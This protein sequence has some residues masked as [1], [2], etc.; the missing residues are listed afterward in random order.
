[1]RCLIALI[2]LSAM[3]AC[4]EQPGERTLTVSE[5][6]ADDVLRAH[7]IARCRENPGELGH[8]PNCR[9]AQEAEGKAR[10]QRMKKALGG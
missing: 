7:H 2:L 8:T 6:V 5:L 1:M 9:N 10:F 4:S 3:A